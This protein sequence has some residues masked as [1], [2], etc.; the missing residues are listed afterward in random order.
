[1]HND[2]VVKERLFAK[3]LAAVLFDKF[4]AGGIQREIFIIN[5]SHS[6]GLALLDVIS[7]WWLFDANETEDSRGCERPGY[8]PFINISVF[9]DHSFKLLPTRL[10]KLRQR[11]TIR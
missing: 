9:E 1:M 6:A 4:R 3:G 7:S 10:T 5:A 8:R 2:I 11:S